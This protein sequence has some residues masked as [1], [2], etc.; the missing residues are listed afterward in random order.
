MIAI[1]EV[2]LFILSLATCV[3]WLRTGTPAA[4]AF[5]IVVVIAMIATITES[6]D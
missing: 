4:G 1:I 6:E 2:I 3:N 5:C